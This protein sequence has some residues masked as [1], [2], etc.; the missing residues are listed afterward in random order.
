MTLAEA[1]RELRIS[2]STLRN[3]RRA[4]R[5]RA[6]LVGKTY[7]T[8]TEEVE[9]YRRASLGRAG[10]PPRNGGRDEE[11][12]TRVD[13]SGLEAIAARHGIRSIALFGSAA[14]NEAGP[15]SDI[16]IVIDLE[17][18][19]TI[20]LFE[21]VGVADE[22]SRLFGRRVDLVTWKALRPRMRATVER[23]AITIF[24]R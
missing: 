22:L 14:R 15:D 18:T 9:R 10:R 6:R 2:P 21:H 16:D 1:A 19:S 7:V 13:P 23:E 24:S 11:G 8:T 20:G 4:G 5:L 17:P 3:Q 12:L